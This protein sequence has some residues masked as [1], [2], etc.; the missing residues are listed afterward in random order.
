M[1]NKFNFI[2]YNAI[3]INFNSHSNKDF[4]KLKNLS[5][6]KN[7]KLIDFNKLI[8]HQYT[9]TSIF[10]IIIKCI[11]QIYSIKII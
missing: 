5:K 11:K 7:S 8:N 1:E 4:T 6:F 2:M 3:L 9:Y 10:Y